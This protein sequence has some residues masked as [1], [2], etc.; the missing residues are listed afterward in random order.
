MKDLILTSTER[1]NQV[2]MI[3][4]KVEIEGIVDT[5]SS[6]FLTMIPQE[7]HDTFPNTLQDRKQKISYSL[8]NLARRMNVQNYSITMEVRK[9]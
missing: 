1:G 9:K 2:A 8:L 3:S 4:G 7:L 6:V 5:D